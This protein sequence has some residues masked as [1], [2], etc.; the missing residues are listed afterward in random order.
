MSNTVRRLCPEGSAKKRKRS[1]PKSPVQRQL[2]RGHVLQAAN[3]AAHLIRENRA[4][5]INTDHLKQIIDQF[6][7]GRVHVRA[8]KVDAVLRTVRLIARELALRTSVRERRTIGKR[9]QGR[10]NDF[11]QIVLEAMTPA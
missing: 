5:T 11:G 7:N 8:Q 4:D 9:V 6:T 10:P 3:T 2:E 1:I